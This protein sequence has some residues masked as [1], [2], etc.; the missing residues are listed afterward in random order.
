MKKTRWGILGYA[1]IAQLSGI[2]AILDAEH[3]E[4]YALASRNAEKGKE[5]QEKFGCSV[6]YDTYEAL[7]E[8]PLVDAVYVPLPNALH[9]EWALKAMEKGKHV[10]CEKP[11]AL[12]AEEVEV[13]AQ[14]SE[15]QGVILMEAFMYRYTT[16]MA[17]VEEILKSGILGD[18]RH[19][20]ATFRFFLNRP[21]TI[22]MKPE[23]G[24][25][26]LYDVGCYPV[27]FAGFVYKE[28]PKDVA[29]SARFQEG[30]DVAA[31]VLLTYTGGQ[32]ATLHTGFDTVGRNHALILGTKGSL[33]IP[34]VFLD[35]AGTLTLITEK[36]TESLPVE[37]CARYTLEVEDFSQAVLEK[38]APK[39]SLEESRRNSAVLDRILAAARTQG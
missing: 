34:D 17:K 36:G 24:G 22:K 28:A 21:N 11:L 7:L 20:D 8:D 23:L 39:L 13:L 25:G 1:R 2:P 15:K 37:A 30:V 32:T 27:N 14:A 31:S 9:K 6:V 26:S 16:R 10:L 19:V 12:N 29:V 35:N 33:E 3:G 38:R 4:F 18:I 5:A